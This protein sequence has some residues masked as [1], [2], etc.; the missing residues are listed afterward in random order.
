MALF[1]AVFFTYSSFFEDVLAIPAI[2]RNQNKGGAL[3]IIFYGRVLSQTNAVE[4]YVDEK[5]DLSKQRKE[6]P[7]ENC[8]I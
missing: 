2:S 6:T 7:T 4:V 8:V 1:P 5:V 3:R